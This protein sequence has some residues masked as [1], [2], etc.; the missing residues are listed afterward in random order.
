ME[1]PIG[2]HDR[3]LAEGPVFDSETEEVEVEPVVARAPICYPGCDYYGGGQCDCE[4]SL[5]GDG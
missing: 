1:F 4:L 5:G 3:Y 2:A